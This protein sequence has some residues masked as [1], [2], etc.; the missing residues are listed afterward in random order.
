M[1]GFL[2][3]FLVLALVLPGCSK[4]ESGN[5]IDVQPENKKILKKQED[6]EI[7]S[8]RMGFDS[9]IITLK[10]FPEADAESICNGVKDAF[11][12]PME[13]KYNNDTFNRAIANYRKDKI[14]IDSKKRIGEFIKNKPVSEKFMAEKGKIK[15]IK[16]FDNGILLETVKQGSGDP[17]TLN[18]IVE[19]NYQAW[20]ANNKL[21]D[22][23]FKRNRTSKFNLNELV[24]GL[25]FGLQQMKKGGRYRLYIPQ[26][27]GY[28]STGH[29]ERVESGMALLFEIDIIN[30]ERNTASQI[31]G[32]KK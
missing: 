22:S 8:Y 6:L 9:T 19:I 16:K 30:I 29:K 3:I 10:N 21:F 18:D 17:V 5:K 28:G 14:N 13:P 7:L 15:G 32:D 12:K 11:A 24:K 26:E 27:M 25:T 20:D 2:M 4:K 1:K 23:S 31:P